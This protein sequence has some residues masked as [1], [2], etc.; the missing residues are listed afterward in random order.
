MG[1]VKTITMIVPVKK[2]QAKGVI[3]D[4]HPLAA[5]C[6]M[7][8]TAGRSLDDERSENGNLTSTTEPS[9]GETMLRPPPAGSSLQ[10]ELPRSRGLSQR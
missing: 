8:T 4:H 2:S 6:R 10:K 3:I 7:P 1:A 5:L 9:E